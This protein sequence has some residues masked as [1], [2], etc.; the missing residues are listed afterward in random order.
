MNTGKRLMGLMRVECGRVVKNGQFHPQ[1]RAWALKANT[2]ISENIPARPL[3]EFGM[4]VYIEMRSRTS[5][6]SA[7]LVDLQ[8]ISDASLVLSRA[9]LV[10][11]WHQVRLGCSG[12]PLG[13][14][15][16]GLLPIRCISGAL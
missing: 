12:A 5:P 4:F 16:T 15:L 7:V 3:A 10:N 1:M 2:F 6:Q 9:S 13:A 14:S 11:L 8:C